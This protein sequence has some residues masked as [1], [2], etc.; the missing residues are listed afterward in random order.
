MLIHVSQINELSSV[1]T[2][3]LFSVQA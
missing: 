2:T 1:M 3:P